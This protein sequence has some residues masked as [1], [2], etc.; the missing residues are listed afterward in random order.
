MDGVKT[1]T[2]VPRIVALRMAVGT[3]S[4]AFGG[5]LVCDGVMSESS[6][7]GGR[8]LAIALAVVVAV[9]SAII[10][11]A[12]VARA[13]HFMR[14]D[15][16]HEGIDFWGPVTR[17]HVGWDEIVEV[18]RQNVALTATALSGVGQWFANFTVVLRSGRRLHISS[19]IRDAVKLGRAVEYELVGRLLPITRSEYAAGH[20]LDFG[21]V[22][23]SLAGITVGDWTIPFGEIRAVDFSDG[24]STVISTTQ[25]AFSG[26]NIDNNRIRNP[27]LLIAILQELWPAKVVL[28]AASGEGCP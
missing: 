3:L 4:V 23:M 27:A 21:V 18:R 2:A 10:G 20:T 14:V 13:V 8:L 11:C 6:A 24:R 5:W 28:P 17:R 22:K 9:P 12:T 16:A 15:V 19:S 1:Y 26:A 7:L 25:P